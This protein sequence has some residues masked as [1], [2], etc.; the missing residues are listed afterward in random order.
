MKFVTILTWTPD[1]RNEIISRRA[2]H[3]NMLAEGIKLIDE[4]VDLAGNRD[5]VIFETDDPVAMAASALAWNDIMTYETFP[6]MEAEAVMDMIGSR[7]E[8][9]G[10]TT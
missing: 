2:E 3:G 1:K 5:I 4:W 9:V 7:K 8:T 10:A 6:V